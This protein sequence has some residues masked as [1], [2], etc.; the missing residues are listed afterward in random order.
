ADGSP[1]SPGAGTYTYPTLAAYARN[2]ADLVEVRIKPLERGTAFR[3]TYQTMLDP[4]LVAATI[5]LGASAGGRALPHGAN[6]QAPAEVFVTVHGSTGTIVDAATG[7][8]ISGVD[9]T[10]D[11]D[12]RRRQVHVCV[13]YKAFDPRND[14]SV[15][16]AVASGLWNIATDA[17][18]IPQ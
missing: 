12:E 14:D 7:K 17:Y 10:V 4:Q 2:A 5:A 15:R 8:R 9:L 11:V 13:P 1:A 16:V 3:L 6:A 18:L